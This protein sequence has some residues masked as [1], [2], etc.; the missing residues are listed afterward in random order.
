MRLRP[1]APRKLRQVT[2][3][4][5]AEASADVEYTFVLVKEVELA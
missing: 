2:E 1:L 3:L 5:D 4:L